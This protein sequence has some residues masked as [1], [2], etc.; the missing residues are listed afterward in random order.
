MIHEGQGTAADAD[1]AAV[2]HIYG[3]GPL[4]DA[5]GGVKR[6]GHAQVVVFHAVLGE[7]TLFAG[8]LGKGGLVLCQHEG[9]LL[10]GERGVDEEQAA[11]SDGDADVGDVLALMRPFER[12][13]FH[14]EGK[15]AVG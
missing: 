10:G 2:R 12:T 5:G 1:L 8:E 9:S 3:F 15:D 4:L 13:R 7:F 6:H 11:V 14:I